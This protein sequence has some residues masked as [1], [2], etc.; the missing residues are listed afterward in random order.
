MY[1]ACKHFTGQVS[2]C[3]L[4]AIK[5][6]ASPA[7]FFPTNTPPKLMGDRGASVSY[8]QVNLKEREFTLGILFLL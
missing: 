8:H 1:L 4:T 2:Y 7:V 3:P 6:N 5:A